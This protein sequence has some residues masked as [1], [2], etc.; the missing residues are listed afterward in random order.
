MLL[1]AAGF[2]PFTYFVLFRLDPTEHEERVVE[3]EIG[4]K[5]KRTARDEARIEVGQAERKHA[6]V[7]NEPSDLTEARLRLRQSELE[8]H[9]A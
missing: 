5:R 8:S 4:V 9:G 7:E 3:A 2:F 6:D 1:A